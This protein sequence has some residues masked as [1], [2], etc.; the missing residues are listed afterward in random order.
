MNSQ[1]TY[2][3]RGNTTR[4]VF[5]MLTCTLSIALGAL[6]ISGCASGSKSGSSADAKQK[7]DPAA[8]ALLNASSAK[9]GAA[10]T[11]KVS[12]EHLLDPK[13]GLGLAI[14]QGRIEL[15]V[16]RPNH[17]YN[18]HPV[19]AETRE[20]AYNGH[21]LCVMHPGEKNYALESLEAK[22]IEEFALQMDAQYGFRPPLAELVA[23]DMAAELLIDVTSAQ[24]LK[25]ERVGGVECEHIRLD[26]EGMITDVWLGVSDKLPYRLLTTITDMPGNP[27]WDF[28]LS[29]W[30][31]NIPLD[32]SLFSKRPASDSVKVQMLPSY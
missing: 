28:R 14:D 12:A 31:L 8:L 20:I 21:Q 16:K 27:K 24:L 4:A 32:E 29:K 17:F 1:T 2:F 26:Q 7:M 5:R 22:N 13:L 19:G 25:K 18:I 15:A 23:S 10:K 3:R 30:Q 11:L 9:L 6:V